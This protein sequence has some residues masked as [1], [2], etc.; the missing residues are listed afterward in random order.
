MIFVKNSDEKPALVRLEYVKKQLI[1]TG[2][3]RTIFATAK[4]RLQ[5]RIRR[6]KSEIQSHSLNGCAVM[7]QSFLS[8]HFI[9][10][11]DPTPRQRS[12]GH[13]TIFWAWLAQILQQNS[14]CQHALSMI[15]SWH[16][17]HNLPIPSCDTSSF[18]RARKRLKIDFLHQIHQHLNKQ[19]NQQTH[20]RLEW[21]K[22]RL[23]AIDASSV[24]LLD[25]PANQET[26]PQPSTQTPGCG[27][28]VMGICGLVNLSHGGWETC[29]S[30]P[31]TMS[32]SK[33]AIPII[34][35]LQQG[36]LLLG[37]RAFCT[38]EIIARS[39]NQNAHILMRLNGMRQ[40]SLDWE[41]GKHISPY[42]RQVTWQKPYHSAMAHLNQSE[43][44]ALPATLELRLI[45]LAFKNRAGEKS[46]LIV[47][48]TLLDHEQ[49]DGIELANLYARRWEME[50][51]LRDLKTTLNM[52]TFAVKTPE[53]AE[54][55]LFITMIA[56]NLI[57]AL[58]LQACRCSEKLTPCEISFSGTVQLAINHHQR[59]VN[60]AGKPRRIKAAWNE[61]IE[62]CTRNKLL[63]RPHRQ[64]PRAVKRRPKAYPLLTK[65]RSI[66]QPIPHQKRYTKNA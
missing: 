40:K 61:I 62:L 31:H 38:Y 32:D 11:I 7:F 6:I 50:V 20:E 56:Y 23:L 51:K 65:H 63:I 43:W 55:T 28:P 53:M 10:S 8:S 39:L 16:S 58:M 30:M 64:E 49:Y 9:Q 34:K 44:E 59:F 27:T 37:D 18:C 15:Q 5:A 12:F 13:Q 60:L 42:E 14:S 19:L 24:H 26:Y 17:H 1:L 35:Q 52:E 29:V 48:T 25:T 57:R 46:D 36:D 22:L 47:V 3:P 4:R 66:F 33:A 54:K 45:K 2:F 41:N 21:K